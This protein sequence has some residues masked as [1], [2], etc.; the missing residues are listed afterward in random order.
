MVDVII[1]YSDYSVSDVIGDRLVSKLKTYIYKYFENFED[2]DCYNFIV[3]NQ[4]YFS[5]ASN[6]ETIKTTKDKLREILR[7]CSLL[8]Y[9]GILN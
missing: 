1:K 2:F 8:D 9:D 7:E 4:M 6:R 3:R 5:N